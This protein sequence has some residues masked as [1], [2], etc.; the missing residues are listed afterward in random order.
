MRKRLVTSWVIVLLAVIILSCLTWERS[1]GW[2]RIR[3][4]NLLQGIN[5]TT[6]WAEEVLAQSA[7]IQFID[8]TSQTGVAFIHYNGATG[9][10]HH[11]EAMGAG[12]AFFDYNNDG[13]LDIYVVN[14]ADLSGK[15]VSPGNVLYRNNGNKSF[16]NISFTNITRTAGVGNQGFGMGVCTADYD[17]NGYQDLYVTNFGANVL[18][19]NNN[20]GTFT[21]VTASAG[22]GDTRWGS[23]CA[24]AD[25]DND[26][27]LDL[28]VA[29]YLDL[30]LVK[31]N[32]WCGRHEEGYRTYCHPDNYEGVADVLYRNN[33]NGTFTNVTQAAGVS[34]PTG[35][36]LGVVFADYDNDG[37]ADIFVANDSTA[38]FL[39]QNNGN[40]IFTEV[41]VLSGVAYNGNGQ[42][43]A[44]MGTD[45]A[46]YDND[47][48]LDIFVTNFDF[49]TNTL[50]R[51]QGGGFF[52]DTTAL[53][54]LGEDREP[55]MG[56]GTKLFD[57][58]ND[59]DKDL[60]IVNGH[61]QDNIQLYSDATTHGQSN[62][63]FRNNGGSRFTEVTLDSGQNLLAKT[64]G[65][66]TAFGDYDND[67]DTD[68]FIVNNGQEAM[69]LRNDGGN[70]NHWLMVKTVGTKSN[71]DGIGARVKVV[72]GALT[73]VAE[74]R[75]GSSYLSENDPRLLFGLGSQAKVDQVEIRW[76]SGIVET[77][78]NVAAN[79]L[80]TLTEQE[81]M[82]ISSL[83]SI[84]K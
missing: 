39:Y 79:Q 30:T 58:D 47:G 1:T 46:D 77:F 53:A 81:G 29:N 80:L 54:G 76:P 49:E 67:G 50:Y 66:G 14:G 57:Y 45:F 43:E 25:Y 15:G 48:L 12:A 69:L 32:M 78:K 8:V 24:F 59:G 51:N 2:A 6:A 9:K 84:K 55:Y 56:W 23:S 72:A 35:K 70:R 42:A 10:K 5:L 82:Q 62:Q 7:N 37:D 60:F 38:N 22:V 33:G 75:S 74:V 73:Q 36:G 52:V 19:R 18:Y 13:Y 4:V 65:R 44:G 83:A 63:L 3:L 71:R 20:D 40:G 21:N 11:A 27:D 16:T 34:N 68:I 61:L 17:N 31:Q 64:V 28:Y 41:G 26:G